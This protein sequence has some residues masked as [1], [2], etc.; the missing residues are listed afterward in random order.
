M[1]LA[2]NDGSPS[3]GRSN[4][5]REDSDVKKPYVFHDIKE[6][7]AYDVNNFPPNKNLKLIGIYKYVEGCH[8]LTTF[9]EYKGQE[10]FKVALNM[11]LLEKYPV[12]DG[13]IELYAALSLDSTPNLKAHFWSDLGHDRDQIIEYLKLTRKLR[14]F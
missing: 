9:V 2:T 3:T 4:D 14:R 10:V 13:T 8:Y 12:I 5:I 1:E 7:L 11:S 6:V